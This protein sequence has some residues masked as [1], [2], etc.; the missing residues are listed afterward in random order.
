MQKSRDEI[1][2]AFIAVSGEVNMIR[3]YFRKSGRFV[4]W[5]LLEDMALVEPDSSP[6]F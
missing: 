2:D 3:P 6:D 4:A 1:C 5:N